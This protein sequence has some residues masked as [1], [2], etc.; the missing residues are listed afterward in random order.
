MPVA[1]IPT[2]AIVSVTPCPSPVERQIGWRTCAGGLDLLEEALLDQR[3]DG[4]LGDPA[5]QALGQRQG[6]AALALGGPA[7]DEGLGFREDDRDCVSGSGTG[8]MPAVCWP[9]PGS[10]PTGETG[11]V[12][13]SRRKCVEHRGITEKPCARRSPAT[14]AR[15]EADG[16]ADPEIAKAS[17]PTDRTGDAAR[18]ALAPAGR[19]RIAIP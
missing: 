5:L 6:D 18:D 17:G 10:S 7:E 15:V 3:A 13:T 12:G 11:R 14:G 19:G 8:A 4:S 9:K 16:S 1:S 2:R